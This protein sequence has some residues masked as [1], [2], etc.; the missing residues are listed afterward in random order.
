MFAPIRRIVNRPRA[1]AGRGMIAGMSAS[2][3]GSAPAEP[4][5]RVFFDGACPLCSREVA[6]LVRRDRR[7]AI[8]FLDIAGPGFDARTWGRELA[9]LMAAMHARLPDGTWVTGVEAFRR[10]YALLGFGFLVSLSRLPLIR[11]LLD[12]AYR[13]FARVRPRLAGRCAVGG[14]CRVAPGG[15][16]D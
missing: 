12:L 5:L 9:E 10:I 2:S 13:G 14:A 15:P 7:R 8:E 11:Q 4:R 1:P 16:A 6:L 3:S